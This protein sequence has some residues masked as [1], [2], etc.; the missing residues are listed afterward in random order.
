MGKK[1]R[2]RITQRSPS[3]PAPL[4]VPS[5]DKR[6]PPKSQEEI[7]LEE[8]VFGRAALRDDAVAGKGKRRLVWDDEDDELVVAKGLGGMGHV[9][10]QDVRFVALFLSRRS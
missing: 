4:G 7:E 8:A 10:D 6:P 1:K 9:E 2:A 5:L 3:P